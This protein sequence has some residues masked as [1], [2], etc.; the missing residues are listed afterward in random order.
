MSKLSA[1]LNPA[2]P[3]NKKVKISNRFKTEKGE[4]EA[5]EIRPLSQEEVEAISK[6]ST[7]GGE[8]NNE[9]FTRRIVVAATVYPD[10]AAQEMCDHYRTMDPLLVPVRMLL[11]GEY[12]R[13]LKEIM[14]LSG[15]GDTEEEL[16]N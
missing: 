10:F 13:L 5:F 14:D 11:P 6:K 3:E 1:F 16:K 9:E 2:M 15:F 12:K 8:I 4:A 7:H